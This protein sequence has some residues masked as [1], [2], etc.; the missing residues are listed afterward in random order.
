MLEVIFLSIIQGVTEFLPVSSSAHLVLISK[1]FNFNNES[2]TLDI[3]LHLGSLLAITFYYKR[4]LV[5]FLVN[6]VL[7]YKILFSSIPVILFGYILIQLDLINFLRSYKVIGWSTV[8]FGALLYISDLAKIK[9]TINNDFKYSSAFY[10][11]LFQILSL[12]P[13]V[14][15]SGITISAGRFLNFS[16]SDSAKISFLISIPALSAVSFFNIF[17]LYQANNFDLSFLNLSAVFLSFFFS[18]ITIK[19]FLI[20]VK[21]FSLT[22]FVIYRILLGSTILFFSYL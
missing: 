4:D 22:I 14:S 20:Y 10:I 17:N 6:R 11:G 2:L 12:I 15:R 3:S 21:K 13:G 1:Y 9:K 5:G 19:Y 16:R 8:L 18:Y 7:F